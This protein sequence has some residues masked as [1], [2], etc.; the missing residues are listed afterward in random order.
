MLTKNNQMNNLLDWYE[1]LLTEKQQEIMNYYYR[2][3]LS[4]SEIAENTETS[5]SAVHDLIKR[6]E[7]ILLNYEEKLQLVHKQKKRTQLLEQLLGLS[8]DQVTEIVRELIE[9]EGE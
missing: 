4:L 1:V 2:E 3:D 8:N 7:Q 6:C 5:R 9:L